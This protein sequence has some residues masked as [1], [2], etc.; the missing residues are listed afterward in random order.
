VPKEWDVL[1]QLL[2]VAAKVL[3]DT[4]ENIYPD[5]ILLEFHF[6]TIMHEL[7]WVGRDRDGGEIFMFFQ[8]LFETHGYALATRRDNVVCLSCTEVTLVKVMC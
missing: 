3:K 1:P 4:G 6:L 5:Q 7:P 8:Y 2:D